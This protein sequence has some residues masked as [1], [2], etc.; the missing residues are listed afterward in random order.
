[1]HAITMALHMHK[2]Q[3]NITD[4]DDRVDIHLLEQ[5][6]DLTSISDLIQSYRVSTQIANDVEREFKNALILGVAFTSRDFVVIDCISVKDL[7]FVSSLIF[8]ELGHV[9]AFRAGVSDKSEL[10][11]NVMAGL[12]S[13]DQRRDICATL[14]AHFKVEPPGPPGMP[15]TTVDINAEA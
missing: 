3:Y 7:Y 5:S 11:A 8:H 15:H 12:L 2:I 14:R 1:M 9:M 4:D 13:V 10:V 6:E